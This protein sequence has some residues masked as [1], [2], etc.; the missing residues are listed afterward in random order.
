[1]TSYTNRQIKHI[2]LLKY[3]GF[4]DIHVTVHSYCRRIGSYFP[5]QYKYEVDMAGAAHQRHAL[6]RRVSEAMCPHRQQDGE[7]SVGRRIAGCQT[8][9]RLFLWIHYEKTGGR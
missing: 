4:H 1:M 6:L 2:E 8:T 9:G 5:L 3:I 7:E